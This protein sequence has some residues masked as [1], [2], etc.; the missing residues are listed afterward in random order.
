[1]VKKIV[2]RAR[3]LGKT[4]IINTA[5][6]QMGVDL[7]SSID[8]TFIST[9]STAQAEP[10]ALDVL[11]L[12]RAREML[13]I[14]NVPEGPAWSIFGEY[15]REMARRDVDR[16]ERDIFHRYCLEQINTEIEELPYGACNVHLSLFDYHH[17]RFHISADARRNAAFVR[18][19]Y[20]E[21]HRR[22]TGIAYEHPPTRERVIA[23]IGRDH[24]FRHVYGRSPASQM[25]E[26]MAL[27]GVGFMWSGADA[28][29]KPE[30]EEK[31]TCLHAPEEIKSAC[32][33]FTAELMRTNF[34]LW[35]ESDSMRNC[36][37]RSYRD[38]IK[39][40]KYLA[41]HVSAPHLG[42]RTGFTFGYDTSGPVKKLFE[43][44]GKLGKEYKICQEWRCDQIRGKANSRCD[45]RDLQDFGDGIAHR[46][47]EAYTRY[48][49][50]K[51]MTWL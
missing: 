26:D 44:R 38:K 12:Q 29:T 16:R 18:D 51:E 27:Y 22:I 15:H 35:E 8:R 14:P 28:K 11:T 30:K 19:F 10:T 40:G 23:M 39:V 31:Y 4:E 7:S 34:R 33:R 25:M 9:M 50:H 47:T 46:L 45:D 43:N 42:F 2:Q 3:G 37:Y 41:Y 21:Y 49:T 17:C 5:L 13:S 6:R 1:M 36:I 32:G 48:E 20:E 24:E